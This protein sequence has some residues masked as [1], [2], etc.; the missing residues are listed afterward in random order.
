M[1]TAFV[2]R[3]D[4]DTSRHS[5]RNPA[6]V[7]GNEAGATG[8]PQTGSPQSSALWIRDLRKDY[9]LTSET[10]HV[11]KGINLDVPRG[12]YVA[13]MGPSGS[14]KSTLLNLLGCLDRPTSGDYHIGGQNVATLSD[15][16]L[17]TIRA[18]NIGFVFQA[19]NLIPQL[20][21][22]ENIEAPLAYLE[23]MTADDHARCQML[24]DQVGL[25]NRTKHRPTELSGGQQQRAGIARS[26]VNNP[27]FIL[28]DEATGNLDTA[29]T[30][31]IL[32]LFDRLNE[33]GAT[34]VAV[35]H[36]EE[37]A[38]RARRI[39]RLRDGIIE[40]DERLRPVNASAGSLAGESSIAAEQQSRRRRRRPSR[41]ALRLR[42]LR[43][44]IKSLMIHPLRSLL[45][46][47][48][49]FIGVASVIWLLAIGEGIA[50]K[51]QEQIEE[52]GAN[53]IILTT[54]R[55]PSEQTRDRR[56][57]FYG[58]TDED[59]RHL[60]RTIPSI[61]LAIPFC[62]RTG[63]ELRYRERVART[64]I[65]ACTPEYAELYSLRVTRGRF[66]NQ[67]D[68]DDKA[69]VCVLTQELV[70]E[71]FR[72]EDPLNRSVRIFRDF[73]RVVGVV[74][75]RM[76]L[77]KVEGASRSQDFSDNS[78]IPIETFWSRYGDSYSVGN[79][80]G[81]GVSQITL[82]L[83]NQ[84]NAIATGNAV[85]EALR[86]SHMFEDYTIGVPL[87]LLEQARNT[88]LMFMGMMGL[89]AGISLVVGG[90]GIMN[91]MLAT[92]TE[93]TREI[94]I[95]RALG[96]KRR[97]ITRQFVIETV[98]LSIAGGVTGILGGLT[99]GQLVDGLRWALTE[100]SPDLMEAMPESMQ[101]VAPVVAPWS[102]P[103][104]FGISV[105]VGIVFGLYPAR[106]AAAMNPIDALRHVA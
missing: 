99:C 32:D 43:V 33:D 66:L 5:Q 82:R 16:E 83:K 13:I 9:T 80:G 25:G 91:I 73:Y 85:G 62:R 59:C 104:A 78:Y 30:N 21:V 81:R 39:V 45:T 70:D 11:L 96:A 17:A 34:I 54:S 46:V 65:N 93:R 87:E 29:T 103:L 2:P 49:I 38:A 72:H 84:D 75:P 53:N 98:L 24:A 105:T 41:A 89:I 55:H 23:G 52:L 10:V 31:E 61:D 57:Y 86:K 6:C 22:L 101:T 7:G 60:E 19:Y 64:E 1:S 77:D 68:I 37:V 36:E 63:Q 12:D 42:D 100:I 56:I 94:G 4:V 69:M 15:D 26:L 106:R 47:L 35:T 76:E 48:G 92:V 44:G 58:L 27:Q 97:D 50:G 88:R 102:I 67:A 79:N 20:T 71:V 40:S 90:I 18:R 95:R 14:G 74:A 51:A 28:A 8:S 3:A